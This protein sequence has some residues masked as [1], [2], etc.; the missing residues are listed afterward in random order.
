MPEQ[1]TDNAALDAAGPASLE[2]PCAKCGG[3]GKVVY[4][5]PP[6][7][8]EHRLTDGTTIRDMGG[9]DTRACSCVA[10]L[11]AHD[12]KATWWGLESV[13][14]EVVSIPIHCEA[15]EI[16]AQVEVPRDEGGRRVHRTARNA[17]Y[18]PLVEAQTPESL[19][20]HAETARELAAALIAAADACD[21]A[22]RPAYETREESGYQAPPPPTPT[23]ASSAASKD[24]S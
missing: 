11:P 23:G 19:T 12:G 5:V 2:R 18:P 14:N 3:S 17:F 15:V 10:G 8:E 22:D 13:F 20:L 6:A 16:D 9:F 4:D 24:P 1:Q 21:E 7:L